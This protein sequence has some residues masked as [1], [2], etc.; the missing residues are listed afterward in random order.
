MEI[1]EAVIH[2]DALSVRGEIMRKKYLR[3]LLA[4]IGVAGSGMATKAQKVDHIV[5]KIPYEFVV[6]GKTLPAGTYNVTRA[7]DA[8]NTV[9][10][11][12]YFARHVGAVVLASQIE[13]S[14]P[15]KAGVSFKRIE[16]EVMLSQVQIDDHLLTIPVSH[17]AI[18]QVAEKSHS[19]SSASGSASGAN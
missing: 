14:D 8:E 7:F 9:V 13:D 3:I 2:N 6:G 10:V 18:H 4:L 19:G 12:N 1:F 15:Q 5:V 17:A 11:L 16:G